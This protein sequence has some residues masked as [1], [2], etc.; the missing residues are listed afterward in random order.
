MTTH[1]ISEAAA[2][3]GFSP[4]ALRYYERIGLMEPAARSS[5]G[6][7]LYDDA[8]IAT[9][10]F[11]ATA[12]ASGLALSDI[13]DL[14]GLWR[15]GE[16]GPV[17]D[18]LHDLLGE[19][20]RAARDE[21]AKL[22]GL[23]ARLE[24]FASQLEG[25]TPPSDC[26]DDCGCTPGPTPPTVVFDEALDAVCELSA[27]ERPDRLGS[28]RALLAQSSSM[29]TAD[30]L[31]R[32]RLPADPGV[33]ARAAE[34]AQLEQDCCGGAL[35]F[36]IHTTPDAVVVEVSGPQAPALLAAAGVDVPSSGRTPR[37]FTSPRP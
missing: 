28:W 25:A 11:A 16:C 33:A 27:D 35:A 8:D 12:K 32:I 15:T 22:A 3:T 23:A 4:D 1:R 9:L 19:R 26:G 29:A 37:T 5:A 20:A 31:I 18:R 7:R 21:A 24:Q 36:T 30:D 13:A 10:R 6:Y 14:V 2:A 17:Q 34:L